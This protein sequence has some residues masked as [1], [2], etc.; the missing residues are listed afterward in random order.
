MKTVS[1]FTTLLLAL[2]LCIS[3][4]T[5][6]CASKE[7]FLQTFDEFS[8]E[9]KSLRTEITDN[10]SAD[11]EKRFMDII[12][13]CYKKHRADLTLEERQEFWKS[14]LQYYVTTFD[15]DDKSSLTA[16]LDDPFNVYVKDEVMD[17]IKESGFS[18][19]SSLQQ[20]VDIELPKLL[21]L[22]SSEI[23]KLS[24]ELL[25]LLQ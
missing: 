13:S 22:F 3:C 20:V 23:S 10:E 19:L 15:L 12:K 24:E 14:G 8:N 16:A 25:N 1:K 21:E 9:F 4:S 7:D 5:D 6:K 18:Y 11:F 2:S 17:V